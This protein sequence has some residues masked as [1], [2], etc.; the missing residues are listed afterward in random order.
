VNDLALLGR[1]RLFDTSLSRSNLSQPDIEKFLDGR[2]MFF[3]RKTPLNVSER[4]LAPNV[5]PK[6]SVISSFDYLSPADAD[7]A[8][9]LLRRKFV[10][11]KTVF[12]GN[13]P[14]FD[15]K[16]CFYTKITPNPEEL[17]DHQSQIGNWRSCEDFTKL[18]H[19]TGWDIQFSSMPAGF[20]QTTLPL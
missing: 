17:W 13:I 4:N 5:L 15:R 18:A 10:N 11:I 1:P 20:Y 6:H 14:D 8:L 16:D 19:D 7:E 2:G 12:I 3:Q 9:R